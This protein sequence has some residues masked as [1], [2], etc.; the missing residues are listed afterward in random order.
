MKTWGN[1]C[2]LPLQTHNKDVTSCLCGTPN[3]PKEKASQPTEQAK[4]KETLMN[5]KHA[6]K[7]T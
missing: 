1:I 7:G 6:G 5:N 2:P 3:N 4:D